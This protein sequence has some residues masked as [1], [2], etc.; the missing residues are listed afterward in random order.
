MSNQQKRMAEAK[1]CL[2]KKE[3]S[4]ICKTF[5]FC[6]EDFLEKLTGN[7]EKA[8]MADTEE[9]LK[10]TEILIGDHRVS[11][12]IEIV[13]GTQGPDSETLEMSV[14]VTTSP[15]PR[16]KEMDIVLKSFRVEGVCGE[17][18]IIGTAKSALP[19]CDSLTVDTNY[20]CNLKNSM[21]DSGIHKLD[22]KV[23]LLIEESEWVITR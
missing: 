17:M 15:W 12:S 2:P 21:I 10:S 18:R 8:K 1:L 5:D 3:K 6:I 11:L 16:S 14:R 23:D 13:P 7:A 9:F 19:I 4:I 22:L 20:V